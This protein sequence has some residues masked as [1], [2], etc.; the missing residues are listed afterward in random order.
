[1][2][3]IFYLIIC[4]IGIGSF[5]IDSYA[6]DS[7]SEQTTVNVNFYRTREPNKLPGYIGN[8][9]SLESNLNTGK[10]TS[11]NNNFKFLPKTGDIFNQ[12]IAVIGL[13]LILSVYSIVL[14]IKRKE[15]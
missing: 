11:S 7:M 8:V 6:N 14:F 4:L 13:F 1:M 12:T 3:K 9:N 10:V 5:T 2:R 15:I